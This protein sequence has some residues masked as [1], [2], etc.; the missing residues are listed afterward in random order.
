MSFH[1]SLLPLGKALSRSSS[2][3]LP[4][5]DEAEIEQ[6]G[7]SSTVLAAEVVSAAICNAI[8]SSSPK[9]HRK[10]NGSAIVRPN[11]TSKDHIKVN[12]DTAPQLAPLPRHIPLEVGTSSLT[13]TQSSRWSDKR[14]SKRFDRPRRLRSH[15]RDTRSTKTS[16]TLVDADRNDSRLH[17]V[18]PLKQG[19]LPVRQDASHTNRKPSPS[20]KVQCPMPTRLI[21]LGQDYSRYPIYNLVTEKETSKSTSSQS[22][23]GSRRKEGVDIEK[24][25]FTEK[26]TWNTSSDTSFDGSNPKGEFLPYLDDRLG[27][28]SFAQ[29]GY[30]FPM[31]NN[32]K[33]MDDDFHVPCPDDD[34]R[35]KPKLRDY[36]VRG[37]LCSLIGMIFLFLGLF[38][39][40]VLFPVFSLRGI[41]SFD[42]TWDTPLSQMDES[43]L[44]EELSW[45]YINGRN[46]SL[47]Q[48]IRSGLIDPTTPEHAMTR[49]GIDGDTLQLVFSDEFNDHNRS[50]YPGDDP[51]WTAAD[52]WYGSTQDLEWYDPDATTTSDG[53]L[54]LQLDKFDNHGLQYRSGMLQSW[55]QLCFK[56]GALEISISLAG[57][58]GIQG[59]W[60]GAW[61]M[62]NLG[63][64]GYQSTTDGTW[65]YTYDSCDA[66]ITP[67]Q[68][69]T[70]GL[71]VLPGQKLPSCTCPDEDH[72]SP[73]KGR[74]A[75]EIDV[76]EASANGAADL[77]IITQSYQVAPFDPWYRPNYDFMAIPNPNFTTMNT[78]CGGP[79][80]QAVSA[81]TTLNHEWYDG[82]KYQKYAYEYTPG[83][84]SSS[85]ISWF[86]GDNPSYLL[87]GDALGPN[88]NVN[89]RPISEEPMSIILN[90]AISNAW[91]QIDWDKL[92]F[93]T[94][95]RVDYVRWYQKKGQESVTCDPPGFETTDYIKK[96]PKA[97]DNANLTVSKPCFSQVQK[98]SHLYIHESKLMY[99][100]GKYRLGIKQD[101]DGRNIILIRS[102]ETLDDRSIRGIG[103]GRQRT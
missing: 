43:G 9:E 52:M 81:A 73:G 37:Q 8:G 12:L 2:K 83:T 23:P 36:L 69:S 32:E 74:G 100:L 62:G 99:L 56:G 82:N 25:E 67:N 19:D 44:A 103:P 29:H 39:L 71:S 10:S 57:P 17:L 34:V 84:G 88:G 27:A 33:E 75:P 48:N 18:S 13:Q 20:S 78:Y 91:T 64:P 26:G 15:L 49:P 72:P 51:F 96:H 6:F 70:D 31:Y 1:G 35:L 86:V 94:A 4:L 40:F 46:Y 54:L 50:F 7:R 58:A 30:N 3:Y 68:S 21:D 89:A 87:R 41:I 53:T 14:R 42:Y 101:M 92:K 102:V 5:K 11:E 24:N 47:F 16:H 55:N 45:D 59:L 90:L 76:I 77:G 61:T 98:D 95:M 85:H 79:G 80:Q 65:P 97:Y 38:V 28:P 22:S 63:R 60:P 66:G 93:P